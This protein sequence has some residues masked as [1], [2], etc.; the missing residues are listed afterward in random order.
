MPYKLAADLL[1]L[2]HLGFIIFVV[3]GGL[4]VLRWPKAVWVHIPAAFWGAWIEF[5]G[6]VCPLTPLEQSL[7]ARAGAD[8]YDG[9]FIDHYI[10]PIIYPPGFTPQTAELLGYFVLGINL[11]IY[12][13]VVYRRFRRQNSAP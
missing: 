9:G 10:I 1:V 12:S 2:I 3:L 6:G 5:A 7:R 4:L 11:L 13:I 8:N